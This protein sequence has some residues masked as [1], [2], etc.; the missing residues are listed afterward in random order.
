MPWIKLVETFLSKKKVCNG[1]HTPNL[2]DQS[3][4]QTFLTYNTS[5]ESETGVTSFVYVP[6]LIWLVPSLSA[7]RQNLAGNFDKISFTMVLP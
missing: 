7:R 4:R 3:H 2:R 6:F 5:L 1:F